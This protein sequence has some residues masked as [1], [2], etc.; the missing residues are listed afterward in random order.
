[1]IICWP[2]IGGGSLLRLTWT[3]PTATW[4]NYFL[5]SVSCFPV[6]RKCAH[7]PNFSTWPP[8]HHQLIRSCGPRAGVLLQTIQGGAQWLGSQLPWN[9]K[10]SL[11]SLVKWFEQCKEHWIATKKALCTTK[12]EFQAESGLCLCVFPSP[13]IF[14][15]L[16]RFQCMRKW[17]SFR[18]LLVRL[19]MIGSWFVRFFSCYKRLAL[20]CGFVFLWPSFVGKSARLRREYF[21]ISLLK[22][23]GLE[24]P[25]WFARTFA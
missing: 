8:T 2:F 7:I 19:C 13:E 20:L 16:F 25:W 12:E 10:T 15:K 24:V 23:S 1:M 5:R 6:N 21:A 11:G 18:S 3:M 14:G 22:A 9:E 17:C 4:L